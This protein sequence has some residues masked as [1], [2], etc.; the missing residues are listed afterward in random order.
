M[1]TLLLGAA[2]G[3]IGG[4]LFGPI[5]AIA[6]RA[7]GALGGAVID[8]TLLGGSRTTTT[9]GAR[10]ANLDVMTSS[11]GA[12]VPRIYGRV[13]LGGQVIWATRLEEVVSVQTTQAGGKSTGQ[14]GQ[15]TTS[16]T[17][18]YYASF[19]LALCEGPISRIGRIWADGKP[20]DLTSVTVRCYLGTPD[21]PPD[22][23]IEAKQGAGNTP[24]Y[25]G[26]AYV[27]FERLPLANFGNRLPQI[28]VEVERAIGDLEAQIR[29]VTLIPGATEFGYAPGLVQRVVGAGAYAPENRHAA[30]AATDL[31][32]SLDQLQAQCPNVRR[33][34]LVVTWF[35][36]DL[37]A[38]VCQVEPKVERAD[39][40]TSGAEW[41][42]GGLT[43]G[44]VGVVSWI[45]GAAAYGGTPS[46][47][48]VL[49]AIRMLQA[50]GLEVTLN[51]FIM[52]DLPPGN[53]RP[54]PWTLG[55]DQAP[56]PWRGRITC[57]PAPG[58]P[59]SPDG[60]AAAEAQVDALFGHAQPTDFAT[61]G[62]LILYLGA[63]EWSLRRMVLHYAHLARIAGGVETLLIGSEMAALT[64]V[65]RAGGGFPAAD[66]LVTLAVDAKSVVGPSGTKISYGANW[67]EYGAQSFSNGQVA[68]PLDRVWGNAAVD[69]VGIDYYAPL[70]D[71]RDGASHLDAVAGVTSLYDR[72]YLKGNL[73]GGEAYDWFYADEA[74]RT[75][76]VRTPITDGAYGEPWIFRQK[77]L[78]SWWSNDHH[79]R[80]G[81]VRSASVTVWQ[82]GSKSIRLM[83]TGCGAVNKGPNRPSTFPDA[84][85]SEG[86]YPPFSDASRDD[87]AQRR[88]LEAI[89]AAFDPAFGASAVDNP[90]AGVPGG[91][92]VDPGG[93]YVWTWDARPFP[94]FPLATAVWADGVNWETGHWLTGRMGTAPLHALVR[95]LCADHGITAIDAEGLEG[96]VDGY[97][98]DQPM[99]ARSALEPLARA[100]AFDATEAD[101]TLAFRPRGG[102]TVAALTEDD[103]VAREDA[104]PLVL[105]RTQE[106][107]LPLEV[108]LSFGDGSADFRHGTVT[109]R[110][111]AGGS[112]HVAR[113]EVAVM[114]SDA[115]MVRAADIWLQDL[116]A[117][118]EGAT[119]SLTAA[120]TALVP[121]DVVQ[122]T[123]DGRTHLLEIT[124]VT[125]GAARAVTAR[126]IDPAVFQA[127]LRPA[128]AGPAAIPA[129][130]GPPLAMPIDLP[131]LDGADP[132][133]LQ[134]LAAAATPWPSTLGVWRSRDGA[135]F[136]LV[137]AVSAPATLGVTLDDLPPGPLWRFDHWTRLRARMDSGV[138]VGRSAAEV[139]DEANAVALIAA[140][141]E[142]EVLQFTEA[143][144]L[145]SGIYRLSGLLRGQAGTEPAAA[146]RWPAGTRLVLLDQALVPLTS[147]L[148]DLGRPCLYRLGRADRD[149][150]DESVA[151]FTATAGGIAVRPLAPVHL[152]AARDAAGITLTWIR[153][154]RVDG[155]SWAAVEIPLGEATELYRVEILAGPGVVRTVETSAP[156]LLYTAAAE[157]AD[158]GAVQ[159]TLGV[160]VAQMSAVLGA[161]VPATA[162][163]RV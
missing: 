47:E 21:Q 127:A 113:G 20:L 19:A 22:P 86:G 28:S 34:S 143:E 129:A 110:R 81:G 158:F 54:D 92:M 62:D 153:R 146:A 134:Y 112:R 55:P 26:L 91:H 156:S 53:G 88:T 142:T 155:D 89:T 94:Q 111:L 56:Y 43:R 79:P 59:G 18:L 46:D 45:G 116:W 107:E 97:V 159:S 9:T 23:W 132:P 154:S 150:G 84:K 49:G 162:W 87:F 33:V 128:Q 136:T 30:S 135:S 40:V 104:A 109:S 64:R 27:V 63:P 140:G 148:S 68:F 39:K 125:D 16:I 75:A 65:R 100:F 131:A 152:A 103:L 138:L 123:C 4:A 3:V 141:R 36:S 25:R 69:F 101:G 122:L 161:G 160:R 83:E 90:P 60:T 29:A 1:A 124:Q 120:Q 102:A 147:G 31:A 80:P 38:G 106:T 5:G 57:D 105:T 66:R 70:A 67:D 72:A 41:S 14:S 115:V 17:Y 85:S 96:I 15:K 8:Q 151:Q 10:L 98:V 11:A 74:A 99:S 108:Q 145:E 52:M 58:R 61:F 42:V 77:D 48:S 24:A 137:G 133:V 118:R 44:D 117:G 163:L 37:R 130:F 73:R 6:G 76:Q 119:F 114:A 121:G 12:G 71:W 82:P 13:R 157:L 2:G 32:A 139:L 95:T 149:A 144:L 50:R 126:S 7:L 93:I 51:P 35:G 78:W